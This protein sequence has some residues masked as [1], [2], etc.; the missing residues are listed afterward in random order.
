MIYIYIA[1]LT[2]AN[3]LV[4]WLGPWISPINAF[5][6]IGLDLTLRDRLHE[7]WQGKNLSLRMG[8][9]ILAAGLLSFAINSDAGIIAI[10]SVVAFTV[11]QMLD[12]LVYQKMIRFERWKKVNASNVVGAGADSIIFPTIAFGG[13]MPEIVALQFTAKVAGGFVW[14]LIL[15]SLSRHANHSKA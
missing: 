14:S 10:A 13:L 9:M 12:A 11:S 15:D 3:L 2:I 5:L 8:G 4:A 6:L 1:S 7:K